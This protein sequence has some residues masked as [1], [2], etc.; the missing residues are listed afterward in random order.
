MMSQVETMPPHVK[1]EVESEFKVIAGGVEG[2]ES[3]EVDSLCTIEMDAV[4]MTLFS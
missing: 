3:T 4:E 1:I 2:V